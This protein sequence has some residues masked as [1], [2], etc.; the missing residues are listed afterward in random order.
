[1]AVY[2]YNRLAAFLVCPVQVTKV[3]EWMRRVL[4]YMVRTVDGGR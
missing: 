1:M 4:R 2:E 3:Q